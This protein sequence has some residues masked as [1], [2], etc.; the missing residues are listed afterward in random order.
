M[1]RV[2]TASI[3]TGGNESIDLRPITGWRF[4]YFYETDAHFA[5]G[6]LRHS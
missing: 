4:F 2:K 3:V 5:A 1:R 6:T